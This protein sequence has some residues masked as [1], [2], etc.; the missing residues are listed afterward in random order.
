MTKTG[1]PGLVKPL[2]TDS[3][4]WL[5]ILA[6][7]ALEKSIYATHST[8]PELSK[9][10][11]RRCNALGKTLWHIWK[12]RM[13]EIYDETYLFVPSLTADTLAA[14]LSEPI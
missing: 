5:P 8:L 2:G 10:R 7:T 6:L 1:H 9:S 13:K 3:L 12:C 14:S 11:N 4:Y